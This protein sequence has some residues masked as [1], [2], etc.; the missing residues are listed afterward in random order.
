MLLH[1]VEHSAW[2][3]EAVHLRICTACEAI[4]LF[5]VSGRW[6]V[7]SPSKTKILAGLVRHAASSAK[8]RHAFASPVFLRALK[9][10]FFT[11][12]RGV[13]AG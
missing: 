2:H 13:M 4:N 1:R 8:P 7:E 10:T 12:I 9:A 3:D 6:I 11:W 5:S